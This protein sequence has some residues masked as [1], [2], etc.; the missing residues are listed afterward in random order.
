[1]NINIIRFI[2]CYIFCFI[3]FAS[4]FGVHWD[5]KLGLFMLLVLGA[6]IVGWVCVKIIDGAINLYEKF[7]INK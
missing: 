5:S 2:I 1:M 6:T 3:L 7:L 4:L